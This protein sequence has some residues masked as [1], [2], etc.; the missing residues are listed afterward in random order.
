MSFDY[1]A[2]AFVFT[3]FDE[4]LSGIGLVQDIDGR[5]VLR[6]DVHQKGA[7][8]VL[9][10]QCLHMILSRHSLRPSFGLKKPN[11]AVPQ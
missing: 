1:Q 3:R 8:T 9:V 11:S 5:S 6:A 4:A 7:I 10:V 2:A